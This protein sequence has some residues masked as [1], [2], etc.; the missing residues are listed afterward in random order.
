MDYKAFGQLIIALR[1]EHDDISG[2]P[3]SQQELAAKVGLTPSQLGRI[4]RGELRHIGRDIV[5]GLAKALEL[6]KAE[7]REF[8]LASLGVGSTDLYARHQSAREVL[9]RMLA[10]LGSIALPAFLHDAYADILGVNRLMLRFLAVR[11]GF[12]ESSIRA[13]APMNLIYY[14]FSP[15][16]GYR[17][18]INSDREWRSIALSNMQFFRRIS[19]RY[20]S[21]T[22]FISLVQQLGRN[23]S[24]SEFW[25]Y[26]GI[27]EDVDTHLERSY[28]FVHPAFGVRVNYAATI[29]EEG[30]A[31]GE[32]YLVTYIPTSVETATLL[33]ELARETPPGVRAFA[34]WPDKPSIR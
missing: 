24:F 25:R 29:A 9:E 10:H 5:I 14:V 7:R 18:M 27:A 1:R 17:D 3:L 26:A 20:R 13:R 23:R 21:T 28:A 15:E 34:S 6:T 32:L 22:H 8:F 12:I 4:E 16:S 33:T 11:E 2:N 31:D 19:L 30:T